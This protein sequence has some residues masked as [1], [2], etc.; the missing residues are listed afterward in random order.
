M[1]KYKELENRVNAL[2]SG[3][4]GGIVSKLDKVFERFGISFDICGDIIAPEYIW[5]A[6]ENHEYIN[7]KDAL[8][9]G[10]CRNHPDLTW[11]KK[12]VE[13][14]EYALQTY[15]LLRDQNILN[16]QDS[17]DVKELDDLVVVLLKE[18]S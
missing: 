1:D 9:C 8:F 15:Y 17:S 5:K 11:Y 18:N 10:N 14:L 12:R 7:E 2:I 6:K 16:S 4:E 3:F 13:S